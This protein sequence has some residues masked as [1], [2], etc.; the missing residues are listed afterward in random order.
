L[1]RLA[2]FGGS[3]S[4]RRIRTPEYQGMILESIKR[5]RPEKNTVWLA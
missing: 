5:C 2:Y 4:K 1:K 3:S